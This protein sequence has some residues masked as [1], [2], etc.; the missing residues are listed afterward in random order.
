MIL[1][2]IIQ[3]GIP[4]GASIILVGSPGSGKTTLCLQLALDALRNGQDVLFLST[5]NTPSAIMSQARSIGLLSSDEIR[6]KEIQFID[7]YSWRLGMRRDSLA[8]SQI[9]NPGNLNEV[10]LVVTDHAKLLASGSLIIIDS[11]SGLSLAAPDEKRIRTFVHGLA[12]RTANLGKTLILVMEDHAHD[13]KLIINLR[14]LVQGSI[15]TKTEEDEEGQ[16]H[17]LLR[18]YSLLGADYST[19]WQKM[20]INQNGLEL[21]EGA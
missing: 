14:A 1:G 6:N 20:Q 11:V 5:E 19:K 8:V 12:Q 16:L 17:W 15:I 21:K 10:N 13:R 3:G 9:S 4:H 2:P 18:I 7:A